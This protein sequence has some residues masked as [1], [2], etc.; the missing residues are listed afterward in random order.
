[1]DPNRRGYFSKT[2]PWVSLCISR[3]VYPVCI[4][5]ASRRHENAKQLRKQAEKKSQDDEDHI[6]TLTQTIT[7]LQSDLEAERAHTQR[8]ERAW[9]TQRIAH[10][11]SEVE[12]E[13]ARRLNAEGELEIVSAKLRAAT[14]KRPKAIDS[15]L[16][17]H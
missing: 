16:L 6:A 17:S 4:D 15:W 13:R 11:Q 12:A 5:Q 7:R 3:V 2:S 10:L 9:H 14:G 8:I 1:M